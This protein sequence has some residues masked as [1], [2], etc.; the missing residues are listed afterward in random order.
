MT[1][2]ERETL[3]IAEAEA[4]VAAA[5]RDRGRL[6][7]IVRRPAVDERESIDA[8][9]LDLAIGL[10]GDG[11]AHRGS[12]S[13]PDGAADPRAQVTLISVRVLATI[14]PDRTRWPLAGDQLYVDL[15]LDPEVLPAGARLA[16]GEALIEVTDKPHTGCAK[17][18][19][20]FGSEAL[21][22]INAPAGRAQRLRGLNARVVQ[23][24]LDP[25]RRHH[26]PYPG[27]RR[28]MT[29]ESA[30][31]A[32]VRA[33]E[34]GGIAILSIGSIRALVVAVAAWTS[35]QR[36]GV[37][38]RARQH[39]G[40]AILL[41]L[42]VLIIADIVQ[43]V[44]IDPTFQSAATLGLIV[45]VRTFLSFS[46]EIELEG[47]VPWHRRAARRLEATEEPPAT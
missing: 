29:F 23:R 42:E 13:T 34:V 12:R 28:P 37:Y 40:Q 16:I 3:D 38:Q 47:V 6:E 27:R 35:G 44:T 11:W 17:F 18:G 5:P 31:E 1:T 24:R 8:G 7:A 4:S 20:R 2:S 46:L 15:A 9:R 39:V 21:R 22:W 10:D 43:T 41:G 32:V 30:M 25:R 33:F 36:D 14:E 45:L 26:R 19:A